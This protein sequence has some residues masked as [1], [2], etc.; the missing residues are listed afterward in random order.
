MS[1]AEVDL[2]HIRPRFDFS[3]PYSTE[4][5][6][7]RVQSRLDDPASTCVG[8]ISMDHVFLDIPAEDQ[9][10]WSP[11]MSF[12]LEEDEEKEG[13]TRIRGLFGPKPSV[14]TLFLF[15][16]LAIGLLGLGF[17]MYGF[18]KW[19]LGD[20]SHTIWG[21]PISLILI[22]TAYLAGKSG[23]KL[24]SDQILILKKFLKQALS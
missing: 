24:G 2:L 16:Y 4:E 23:E 12:Y 7:Q 11:Q 6:I 3:V 10:F 20:Y 5:I 8:K 18:S 15:F 13:F 17:S 9:H 1:L 22:S 14:W 21:L 19:S